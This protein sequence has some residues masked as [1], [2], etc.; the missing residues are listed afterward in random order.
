[1]SKIQDQQSHHIQTFLQP[2]PTTKLQTIVMIFVLLS[3]LR[4]GWKRSSLAIFKFIVYLFYL[5]I[6]HD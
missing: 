3:L 1:M 5:Q 2:S 6:S 4:V